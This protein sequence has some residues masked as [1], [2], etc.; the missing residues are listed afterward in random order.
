[1]SINAVQLSINCAGEATV[2]AAQATGGSTAVW[3]LA[4]M[5]VKTATASTALAANGETKDRIS[6]FQK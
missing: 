1:L 5:D 6:S 4:P 3:A 2:R